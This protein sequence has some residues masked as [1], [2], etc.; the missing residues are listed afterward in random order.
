MKL[1]VYEHWRLTFYGP[2]SIINLASRTLQTGKSAIFYARIATRHTY[3]MI[4]QRT[5]NY[6]VVLRRRAN[7]VE[8]D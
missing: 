8:T 6:I 3:K 2:S 5:D 7:Y 4:V 1:W